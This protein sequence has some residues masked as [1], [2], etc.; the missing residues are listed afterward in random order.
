MVL[1][2]NELMSR[3]SDGRYMNVN[4]EAKENMNRIENVIRQHP[5][6]AIIDLTSRKSFNDRIAS[7]SVSKYEQVWDGK[8]FVKKDVNSNEVKMGKSSI[9]S[10]PLKIE[11]DSPAGT[12]RDGCESST[13]A[14]DATS[15][16]KEKSATLPFAFRTHANQKELPRQNV[17]QDPLAAS[18]SEMDTSDIY[19][20]HDERSGTEYDTLFAESSDATETDAPCEKDARWKGFLAVQP[21]QM[22]SG[23]AHVTKNKNV[24][25]FPM[26]SSISTGEQTPT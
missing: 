8:T 12:R 24:S 14:D 1:A 3:L 23:P 26:P 4:L 11:G 25:R 21:R 16:N 17:R 6:G 13:P 20:T 18:S 19:T 2:R 7:G 5:R 22:Q 10:R 15:A 9:A